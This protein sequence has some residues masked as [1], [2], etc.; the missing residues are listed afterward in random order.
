MCSTAMANLGHRSLM[1]S[2]QVKVLAFTNTCCL[3]RFTVLI[4]LGNI[5][6][7]HDKDLK[8]MRTFKRVYPVRDKMGNLGEAGGLM[9]VRGG[10]RGVWYR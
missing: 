3:Q 7:K 4:T 10:G 5:E 6:N 2:E 9:S 8:N 1:G